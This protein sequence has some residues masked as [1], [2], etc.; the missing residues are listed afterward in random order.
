MQ[1]KHS[2]FIT[3]KE[4]SKERFENPGRP[5]L[6]VASGKSDKSRFEKSLL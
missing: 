2:H 6:E 3:I 5:V 1:G 4:Q